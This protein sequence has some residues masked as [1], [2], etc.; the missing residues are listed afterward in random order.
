MARIKCKSEVVTKEVTSFSFKEVVI[1][2]ILFEEGELIVNTYYDETSRF[3]FKASSDALK[4]IF[5]KEDGEKLII[6]G[7]DNYFI[8][9]SI[10]IDIYGN[11]FN[12]INLM[13]AKTTIF[14]EA[15][16]RDFELSF[17]T[18]SN[19]YIDKLDYSNGDIK[20]LGASCLRVSK[21]EGNDLDL[22]VGGA[23]K[24]IIESGDGDDLRIDVYGASKAEIEG[25]K[26]KDIDLK[27]S[28]ASI[29]Q[30]EGSIDDLDARIEGASKLHAKDLSVNDCKLIT[31]GASVSEVSFTES[32]RLSSEGASKIFYYSNSDDVKTTESG[33][34]K[35]EKK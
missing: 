35:I 30:F 14:G 20:V 2:G 6:N 31:V 22:E 32:G 15:L 33:F 1:K 4:N 5:V 11:D 12:Y 10:T 13:N 3:L 18:A 16:S 26:F 28:G 29:G 8:T 19:V 21:I 25:I 7:R 9:D 27:V 17:H 34:G 23:S 24:V